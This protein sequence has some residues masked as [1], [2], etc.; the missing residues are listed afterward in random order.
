MLQ[1]NNT[2]YFAGY[3][4]FTS[5]GQT[6]FQ[7][8]FSTPIVFG[9]YD[10][11]EVDYQK[12]N[13]KIYVST[14]AFATAYTEYLNE[15]TVQNGK[16]V[17]ATPVASGLR[18]VVQ[19]KQL[20]G[21]YEGNKT[22]YGT[23]V[24]KNY[25]SYQYISIDDIVDEFMIGYVGEGKLIPKAKKF[26]IMFHAK[27][28]LQELSFNTLRTTKSLEASIPHTL[29]LIM[30][31]DYI[32]YIQISVIDGY[33][34]KHP[35]LKSTLK[36]SP[37]DTSIQD[38]EGIPVQDTF[39]NNMQGE[40]LVENRINNTE[41]IKDVIGTGD[42]LDEVYD[43]LQQQAYGARFGATPEYQ[44]RNGTFYI[45]DREG[46][47]GFDSQLVNQ[48]VLIEYL[49]DGLATN[50]E[51]KIPKLATAAMFAYLSHAIISTR[52]GQPEYIVNRLKREKSAAIRNLK[53]VMSNWKLSE[54]TQVLRNQSKWIKH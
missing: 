49:S 9:N 22:A 16:F 14:D 27:R 36:S 52:A 18:V 24:E 4:V 38:W 54:L 48:L 28:A 13:F 6:E 5:S 20:K 31:Q 11:T 46:K 1:E 44:N 29:Q 23:T 15:Y 37:T 40:S 47:I 51:T 53:H 2:Q 41:L 26:D 43:P 32:D 10:N 21:G 12:N 30:P 50:A 17:F 42:L 25:G 34:I 45:I 19:L 3:E 33:G 7:T 35:L 39:N 8:T